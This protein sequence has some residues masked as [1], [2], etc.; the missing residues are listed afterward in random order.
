MA[1]GKEWVEWYD[2][3]PIDDQKAITLIA[4]NELIEQEILRFDK[5]LNNLYWSTSGEDLL[6]DNRC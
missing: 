3:L 5:E 1:V 2:S 6:G 4:V